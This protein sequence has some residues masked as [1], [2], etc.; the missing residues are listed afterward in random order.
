MCLILVAWQT[1]PDYPLIVA[2][3]RDEFHDRPADPAGPWQALPGESAAPPLWGGRDRQAGGTWLALAA[4]GRFAAVTNVREPGMAAGP[5]SRGDL[6]VNFLTAPGGPP[7][8]PARH[9]AALDGRRYS[10]Y[11]LLLAD[12]ETLVYASNRNAQADPQPLPPGIYGLSNH[13]LDTPWPK[14][15][16]ARAA[17]SEAISRLPDTAPLFALLADDRIVDDAEL[18]STGVSLEWERRLSAIFVR[19]PGYGT[20]A[21]TVVLRQR[22]GCSRLLERRFDAAGRISGESDITLPA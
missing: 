5:A 19:S 20:R 17:F 8:C 7:S 10:G 6:P 4:D 18:P 16:S 13:R 11:N 14:L 12:R 21:S 3:N 2:A 9:A 1:H 15:T 22:D